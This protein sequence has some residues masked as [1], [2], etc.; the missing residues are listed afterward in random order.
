MKFSIGLQK[1]KNKKEKQQHVEDLK[2]EVNID[3]HKITIEELC[4]RF[5]TNVDKG[6]TAALA[7]EYLER[8]G[9]VCHQNLLACIRLL[10][11]LTI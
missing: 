2:Q 1:K 4:A 8:D 11:P 5:K 10:I 7:K 3:D 9:Y 6:L